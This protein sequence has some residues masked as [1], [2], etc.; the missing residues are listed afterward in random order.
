MALGGGTFLVQNK[1]L[2]GAY[3]NF[4]SVSRATAALSDR[5]IG[6]LPFML[7]WGPDD[8]VFT[9]DA[10]DL[11]KESMTLFGYNYTHDKLRPLRDFFRYARTGYFYRINSGVKAIRFPRHGTPASA[12]MT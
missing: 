1:K 7:D 12:G 5:G 9:V 4:V 6:A 3:I 2:P 11:Q 8:E 10:A